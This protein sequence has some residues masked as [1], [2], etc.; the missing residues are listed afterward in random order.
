MNP[1]DRFFE[2]LEKR[3]L[4]HFAVKQYKKYRLAAGVINYK[5]FLI[6]SFERQPMAA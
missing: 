6:Q 5:R 2:A 3:E 1:I 4:T